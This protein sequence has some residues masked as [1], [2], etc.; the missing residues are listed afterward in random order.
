MHMGYYGK[1]NSIFL[2]NTIQLFENCFKN[3][4]INSI[5]YN[6]ASTSNKSQ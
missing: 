1:N 4:N 6:G 5:Y 2:T 3:I